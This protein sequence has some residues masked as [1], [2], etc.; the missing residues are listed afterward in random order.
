M[1][2]LPVDPIRHRAKGGTGGTVLFR[3]KRSQQVMEIMGGPNMIMV[4]F[5]GYGG[6]C[7]ISGWWFGTFGLFFPSYWDESSQ[8]IDLFSEGLKPP[9]G[10]S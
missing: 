7:L 1:L 8:L 5:M 9:T 4:E 10:Y 3:G 2:D 6:I